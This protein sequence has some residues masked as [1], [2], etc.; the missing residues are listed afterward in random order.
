MLTETAPETRVQ[1]AS[2]H[3]YEALSHHFGPLDLGAHQPLVLAISE[4]AKRCR[5]ND[6]DRHRAGQHEGVR[7]THQPLRPNGP[8]RA[9]ANRHRIGGLRPSVPAKP[10]QRRR[11]AYASNSGFGTKLPRRA[12]GSKRQVCPAWWREGVRVSLRAALRCRHRQTGCAVRVPRS[13]QAG[14]LSVR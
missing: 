7:G 6:E 2:Q 5:Q 1:A 9:P 3:L 11:W 4:Y 12:L 14:P 13:G 8:W 10:A